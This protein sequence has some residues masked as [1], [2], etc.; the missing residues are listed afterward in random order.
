MRNVQTISAIMFF[1]LMHIPLSRVHSLF[2]LLTG[3]IP[4]MLNLKTKY[5]FYERANDFVCLFFRRNAFAKNVV[6]RPKNLQEYN[7]TINLGEDIP[8]DTQINMTRDEW[9]Q[10]ENCIWITVFWMSSFLA[11]LINFMYVNFL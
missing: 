11:L 10:Q 3:L 2:S 7:Q 1:L 6:K 5:W 4:L 8:A 9:E